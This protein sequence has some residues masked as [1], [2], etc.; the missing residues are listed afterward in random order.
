MVESNTAT[1]RMTN[2][3]TSRASLCALGAICQE[4]QVLAPLAKM[5]HIDQKAVRYKPTD[6]LMD[7]LLA[8]LCGART[9]VATNTTLRPDR[10]VSRAFGRDGC[11]EQSTIWETIQACNEA[12]LAELRLAL[13]DIFQTQSQTARHVREH[14]A[15]GRLEL[16]LDLSG[17]RASKRA[18]ASTKGYFA[19]ERHA[20]GRQLVRVV[21]GQYR[22][23]VWQE[24]VAGNTASCTTL[25]AAVE[26]TEQLLGLAPAD[27]PQ[28]RWRL[29]AGFGTFENICW[30][31]ARGYQVLVKL[32]SPAVA[33]KLARSVRQWCRAQGHP[34]RQCGLVTE[35]V[36]YGVPTTQIAVRY[37]LKK[38]GYGYAVLVST[39]PMSDPCALA[40]Q[41]D[42]RTIMESSL[43]GDK[44][45]LA[46]E[47]RRCR[48][49][50][51]QQVLVMLAELAHNLLTWAGQWLGA[52]V[53]QVAALGVRRLV[54][55]V[56][57]IAGVIRWRGPKLIQIQL[58]GRHP[59]APLLRG[60]LARLL[61]PPGIA[62]SLGKS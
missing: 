41:Y 2:M 38:G 17:L 32:Y 62:V 4:R 52:L 15:A 40:D 18:E 60:A 27:R 23:I 61:G 31:L 50:A 58:N 39:D 46:L 53:K 36:D 16:E 20:Y 57:P 42:G 33:A 21:A 19:G 37:P 3:R 13:R 35:A 49:L 26:L 25:Q 59:F 14:F 47:K 56:I 55:E 43:S 7:A 11:A 44:G 51:A 48:S 54:S 34:D 45:G 6:K 22:E 5:I 30:L 24:A 10:A 8:M 9:L 28:V 1:E 29:D 12:N